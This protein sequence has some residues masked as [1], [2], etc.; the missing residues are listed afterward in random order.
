MTNE[1]NKIKQGSHDPIMADSLKEI[2]G[3]LSKFTDLPDITLHNLTSNRVHVFGT[4]LA[5]DYVKADTDGDIP[6]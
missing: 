4:H 1:V 2:I 3:D 5:V 6:V